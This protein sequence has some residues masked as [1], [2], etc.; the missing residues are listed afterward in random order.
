M[1]LEEAIDLAKK[2]ANGG[3]STKPAV[4]IFVH[5][6]KLAC[7]DFLCDSCM[8]TVCNY[9]EGASKPLSKK[10]STPVRAKKN[11]GEVAQPPEKPKKS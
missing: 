9:V 4:E 2:N 11:G 3:G 7:Y 1:T 8:N 6:E 5:G 10:S